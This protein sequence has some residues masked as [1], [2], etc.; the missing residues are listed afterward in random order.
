MAALDMCWTLYIAKVQELKALG[1]ATWSMLIMVFGAGVT[2][3]YIHNPILLIGAAAGAFV[4]TWLTVRVKMYRENTR[5]TRQHNK[6]RHT[7]PSHQHAGT[8]STIG[9]V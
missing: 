9:P 5:M 1:A 3:S 4:G 2:I 7:M 8:T 6:H